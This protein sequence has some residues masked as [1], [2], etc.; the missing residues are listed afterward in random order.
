MVYHVRW[1]VL[2]AKLY[3]FF[4]GDKI[5]KHQS[6][7]IRRIFFN[8][9]LKAVLLVKCDSLRVII[10]IND[11]EP[12]TCLVAVSEP[13]FYKVQQGSANTLPKQALTSGKAANF[14]GGKA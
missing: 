14:D 8:K 11:N 7:F 1:S 4:K 5:K 12:T 2:L 3:L 13:D 9:E 10:G 6:R